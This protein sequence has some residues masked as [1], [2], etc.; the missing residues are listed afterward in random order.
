MIMVTRDIEEAVTLA[1]KI[2]VLGA[3]RDAIR[4]AIPVTLTRRGTVA[5]MNS[6]RPGESCCEN[7]T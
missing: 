7:S 4:R 2:V 6:G 3:G 5:V 1:D